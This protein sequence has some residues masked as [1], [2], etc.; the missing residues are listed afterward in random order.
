[1]SSWTPWPREEKIVKYIDLPLQHA[2]GPILKAMNRR[3]DRQSLT[4]LMN[5]IRERVPGVV[6]RTTLIT[7]FPGETEEDF[8]ELAEFVKDVKFQRPGL[9]RLLPGGGHPPPRSSPA[10]WM[11]K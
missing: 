9:L 4:A 10:S 11:R 6:L 5:K 7:G 2:S 3:G 1:M 8:T